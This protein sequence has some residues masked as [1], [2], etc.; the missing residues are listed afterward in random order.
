MLQVLYVLGVCTA[1]ALVFGGIELLWL[2]PWHPHTLLGWVI[3]FLLAIP[4]A[5]IGVVAEHLF[6]IAIFDKSG[7]PR[8]LRGRLLNER[9]IVR[10]L[11]L[12]AII[13]SLLL[14]FI[15]YIG[16]KLEAVYSRQDF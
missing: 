1:V 10:T 8:V 6:E 4:I 16:L 11:T 9:R 7:C 13:F 12:F 15:V 3:L 5:I 2:F 14:P